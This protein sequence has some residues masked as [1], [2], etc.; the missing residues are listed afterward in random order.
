MLQLKTTHETRPMEGLPED[1]HLHSGWKL[2][3]A[4]A[5]HIRNR[6]GLAMYSS[7]RPWHIINSLAHWGISVSREYIDHS[8]GMTRD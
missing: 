3:A 8:F 1:G 2:P 6:L 7:S 4:R 5:S